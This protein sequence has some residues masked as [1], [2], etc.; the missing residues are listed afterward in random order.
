MLL[1]CRHLGRAFLQERL[2]QIYA[3]AKN[4]AN[5][6]LA[7]EPLPIRPGMHYQMGGIKTDTE[8]RCWDTEGN[9]IGLPGLFAAG[10]TACVSLHGGNRLGA[11]SL[12]D[13]IVFGRRAGQC[14]AEY[15]RTIPSP[16]NSR[17]QNGTRTNTSVTSLLAREG[18]GERAAAIRLADGH[19]HESLCLGFS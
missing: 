11:N 16:S 9:W 7:E 5:I 12:L 15:G 17:A 4:F 3:E 10:E 13:T 6:D 18:P 8:G 14:A 2:G 19:H 1:D